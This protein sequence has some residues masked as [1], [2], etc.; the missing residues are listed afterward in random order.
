MRA[1]IK[2]EFTGVLENWFPPVL[3]DLAVMLTEASGFKFIVKG[4]QVVPSLEVELKAK[5]KE[6]GSFAL[7]VR[8]EPFMKRTIEQWK[9]KWKINI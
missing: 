2:F 5:M 3:E 6:L 4:Y 8:P 9:R 7:S 1:E